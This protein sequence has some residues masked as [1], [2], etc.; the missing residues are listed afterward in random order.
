MSVFNARVFG[1]DDLL[2]PFKGLGVLV[3][4]GDKRIDLSAQLAR[5]G[6]AEAGQALLARIENQTSTWLSQDAWVGMK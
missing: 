6:A 2:G 5:R 3:V 1:I 4:G